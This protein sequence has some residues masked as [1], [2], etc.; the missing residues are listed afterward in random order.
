LRATAGVSVG[1]SLNVLKV[2]A[3]YGCCTVNYPFAGLERVRQ[4]KKKC[5]TIN[6]F[7]RKTKSSCVPS[8]NELQAQ[9]IRF[10]V[11]FF[12]L[13]AIQQLPVWINYGIVVHGLTQTNGR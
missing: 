7:C 2:K 3:I 5:N 9:L 10:A 13:S 6:E 4:L 8:D 12:Q 1:E 11:H